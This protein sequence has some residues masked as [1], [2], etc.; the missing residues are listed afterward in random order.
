MRILYKKIFTIEI[1][2]IIIWILKELELFEFIII[3]TFNVKW[4]RDENEW[5][6]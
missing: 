3:M 2:I 1:E 6:N 5:E 4:M